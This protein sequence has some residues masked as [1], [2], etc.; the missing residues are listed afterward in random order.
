MN[1]ILSKTSYQMN[2]AFGSPN[3]DTVY[4]KSIQKLLQCGGVSGRA[5]DENSIYE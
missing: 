1:I 3:K 4:Y 2:R 5:P